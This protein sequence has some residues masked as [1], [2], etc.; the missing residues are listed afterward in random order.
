MIKLKNI[1]REVGL[2][3]EQT[4]VQIGD[5]SNLEF[6]PGRYKAEEIQDQFEEIAKKIETYQQQGNK[7]TNIS[8]DA[9]ESQVN[10]IDVYT[11]KKL[12]TGKLGELRK[13][14]AKEWFEK[15][16]PN[17]KITVTPETKIGSEPWPDYNT[18]SKM[19]PDS[20]NKLAQDPKY[21]KDQWVRVAAIG[22]KPQQTPRKF[23]FSQ[24]LTINNILGLAGTLKNT[25]V[26][27][28]I[29]FFE[30]YPSTSFA[31]IDASTEFK[32]KIPNPNLLTPIIGAG[33]VVSLEQK[34]LP[35]IMKAFGVNTPE[36]L[37]I[38]LGAKDS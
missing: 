28:L 7:V 34:T 13:T 30:K 36:E 32:S 19:T 27:T 1:L 18:R 26:S 35:V 25:S 10:N 12:D 4:E 37:F 5:T 9:S 31:S 33:G 6:G 38:I 21:T 11:K 2:L 29:K 17:L 23:D 20:I 24:D 14:A 15:R 16:F 22:E 3:S 8:I